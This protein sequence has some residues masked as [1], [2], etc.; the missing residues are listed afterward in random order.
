[1]DCSP[2]G[3]ISRAFQACDGILHSRSNQDQIAKASCASES[4]KIEKG[5]VSGRPGSFLRLSRSLP[6]DVGAKTLILKRR[7][8]IKKK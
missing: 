7:G 8:V 1:V 5:S 3:M 4:K 2:F 6:P